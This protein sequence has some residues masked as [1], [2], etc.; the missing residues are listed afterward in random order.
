MLERHGV[1][2]N[3]PKHPQPIVKAAT[4]VRLLEIS[5]Y[6]AQFSKEVVCW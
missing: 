1:I 5:A 6:D 3:L 4:L 2:R